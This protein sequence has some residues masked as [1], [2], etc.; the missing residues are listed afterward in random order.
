MALM[1]RLPQIIL[2]HTAGLV[3]ARH[4]AGNAERCFIHLSSYLF[5]SSTRV[6][7]TPTPSGEENG[8]GWQGMPCGCVGSVFLM[9]KHGRGRLTL[10]GWPDLNSVEYLNI[11]K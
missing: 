6:K 9:S 7:C 10:G 8:R 4:Q 2:A 5:I 3:D 1:E 11:K